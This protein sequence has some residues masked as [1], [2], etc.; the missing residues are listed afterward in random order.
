[1]KEAAPSGSI[2][3]YRVGTAC[4]ESE[5]VGAGII[6]WL[7]PVDGP[8]SFPIAYSASLLVTLRNNLWAGEKGQQCN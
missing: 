1:M 5:V 2:R 8:V 6:G 3:L 4:T 7:P